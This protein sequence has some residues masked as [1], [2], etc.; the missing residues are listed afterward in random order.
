MWFEIAVS[1]I[2]VV[3][4][5]IVA[6]FFCR[7]RHHCYHRHL[8]HHRHQCHYRRR[9]RRRRRRLSYVSHF[10]ELLLLW[11]FGKVISRG[12]RNKVST[13]YEIKCHQILRVALEKEEDRASRV[14]RP[15]NKPIHTIEPWF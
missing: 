9:R 10:L 11:S 1:I 7:Y 12:Q 4:I 3:T 14:I 2:F 5:V 6:I 15:S 8:R 13:R